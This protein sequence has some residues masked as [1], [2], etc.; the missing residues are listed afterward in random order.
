MAAPVYDDVIL[1][2]DYAPGGRGGGEW[3]VRVVRLPSG[4]ERRLEVQPEA[5]YRFTIDYPSLDG[6][7]MEALQDFWHARRGGTHAFRFIDFTDYRV[8][9]EP[10]TVTGAPTVQLIRTYLSGP[11]SWVRPIYA[12]AG[13]SPTN[14]VTLKKNGGA[15]VAYTLGITTGLVTLTAV[16][17]K[18]ITAISQAASAVVTV[19]A[20]HGFATNDLVYFSGVVGMTQI[21]GL[22]GTVTATAANTITVNI[23]STGFSAYVSGGTAAK[24]MTT[25]DTFTW[26]GDFHVPV[27]FDVTWPEFGAEAPDD[28]SWANVQLLEVKE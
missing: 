15:F 25:T 12:P 22:V 13:P 9:D 7:R 4:R 2:P 20:A 26:S 10:L 19:G 1:S 24:Y 28:L 6:P 16:N 17:S 23:A 8:T 27:R 11:R 14:T 18:S 21:N 3:K 5:L